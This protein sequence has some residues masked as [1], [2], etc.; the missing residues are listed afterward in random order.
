[1]EEVNWR[2]KSRVLWLKE[3]DKCTKFFHS[4]ANSNRRH[5]AF[6][7][8]MI[9]DNPSSNQT[10]ISEHIVEFY[11]KMFFEQCRWRPKVDGISF[12]SISEVEAG[13]LERDFEEEEVRKVVFKLNGDKASGLEG[14]LWPSSKL[15]GT[16]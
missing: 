7:T 14:F 4:I 2:Q 3:G 15:V 13:W 1:M 5:N 16:F 10:E 6:D 9:G 11:Q 12:D 8:L